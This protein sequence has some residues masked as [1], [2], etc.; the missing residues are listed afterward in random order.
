MKT[1]K[2]ANATEPLEFQIGDDVF[3]AIP[4]NRLPGYVLI[5]YVELVQE[6]KIYKAHQELFA[7]ALV[8]ESSKLFLD[9]LDSIE[10]P[11]TLEQMVEVAEWLT[12]EYSAF[13]TKSA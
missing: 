12:E 4:A 1:F 3:T 5:K 13:T 10:N 6:G 2:V 9:R 11:I 8:A 7:K